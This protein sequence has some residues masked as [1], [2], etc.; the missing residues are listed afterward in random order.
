M[1]I[2][3]TMRMGPWIP[4][5]LVKKKYLGI[6][7][8]LIWISCI[9]ATLLFWFYWQLTWDL[10]GPNRPIHFYIYLP[11]VFFLL[12]VVIVLSG[13]IFSKL[14]LLIVNSIRKPRTGTF[15]RN[16]LDKDYKYWILRNTIKRWPAWL[17]HRFP[18]PFLDNIVFKMFG[19]K[20]KFSNSL[21]EGWVDTE[22]IEFGENVII[23]QGAIIQSTLIVGNLLIIR[24]TVIGSDVRIGTH[25]IVMP[26]THIG[27]N[28]ILA[29]NSV[30]TVEQVLRGNFI[31]M[32]IPASIIKPNFFS[33]D[34]LEDKM[35]HVK[36]I[37]E[38]RKKYEATYLKRYDKEVKLKERREFK[39]EKKEDEKKRIEV[40]IEDADE[41]DDFE[42]GFNI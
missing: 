1:S 30:T 7:V 40:E 16:I 13:L 9:P 36:S 3:N 28:T 10:G 31:Y 6:Y 19:V 17:A 15:I 23:G 29:A 27:D 38:V 34:Y 5:V 25:A 39:K 32:G 37:E 26:G 35:S 24:K 42:D 21:F 33:E 14:M 12:Y 22:F 11:L 8:F 20:T 4:T 41:Y 2:P 18:L